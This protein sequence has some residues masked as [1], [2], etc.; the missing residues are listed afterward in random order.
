MSERDAAIAPTAHYTAHVWQRLGLPYASVF[1]TKE[2]ARLFWGLRLLGEWVTLLTPG[3]PTMVEYLAQR[4]LLIEAALDDLGPDRIVELGA[5]LSRR[6]VTW[7]VDRSVPYLEVD[8]PHMVRAKQSALDLHLPPRLRADVRARLELASFDVLGADFPD[9][10][11]ARFGAAR[12]PV[13]VAE[14][15][16][17]YF[18]PEERARLATGIARALAGVGGGA[19]VCDLRSNE[20]G[21]AIAR[22]RHGLE[23]GIKLVTRGRG[24]RADFASADEVRSFFARAGFRDAA[25]IEPTRVPRVAQ[26]P[27]PA[28]IWV[29][30][31]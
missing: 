9:W 15:L 12:R 6:G 13:V 16:V 27:S 29:A 24:S 26:I 31:V 28:R 14:G 7:A 20:G 19:F 5:G 18:A 21:R 8:L 4:H 25:P 30:R 1:A 17:G 11:T 10:L 2:G 22:A 3:V 23:L